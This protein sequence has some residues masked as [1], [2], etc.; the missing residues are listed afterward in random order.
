MKKVV[1]KKT[2]YK[3]ALR[4]ALAVCSTEQ[5]AMKMVQKQIDMGPQRLHQ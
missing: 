5:E 4:N 2:I 3:E 1:K